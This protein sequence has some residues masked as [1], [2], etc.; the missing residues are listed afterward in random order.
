MLGGRVSRDQVVVRV[1]P[2]TTKREAKAAAELFAS[3]CVFGGWRT[4]VDAKAWQHFRAHVEASL[5]AILP[6]AVG[7]LGPRRRIAERI[8]RALA[9]K[10]DKAAL[11]VGRA[12]G[13]SAL[14]SLRE[15]LAVDRRQDCPTSPPELPASWTALTLG[16]LP[17][18]ALEHVGHMLAFSTLDAPYVGLEDVKTVCDP[19]A[20]A[21]LAWEA[22]SSWER[23]GAP[24]RERWMVEAIA[25]FG[26]DEVIRRTTP[27][28]RDPHVIT[29]VAHV[30]T[31]AAATELCTILARAKERKGRD[32]ALEA[33]ATNARLR[34]MSVEELEDSI[35]PTT[36]TGPKGRVSLGIDDRLDAYVET[37]GGSKHR[38][39]PS[40]A[41]SVAFVFRELQE[42]LAAIAEMRLASLERAMLTG[43]AW[44]PDAFRRAWTDHPVMSHVARC[45]VWRS[46]GTTFRVAEDGTFAGV[47]DD[48]VE[49]AGDVTVPH[50]A[51]MTTGERARWIELFADYRIVQPIE[52]LARRVIVANGSEVVLV[53]V[54]PTSQDRE[55]WD[56]LYARGFETVTRVG[57]KQAVKRRGA[58]SGHVFEA[59]MIASSRMV[60][61][62]VVPTPKDVDLVDLSELAHDLDAV[63]Q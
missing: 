39:V 33:F 1:A 49:V 40:Q 45:V 36:A 4:D 60:E 25:H 37:A 55:L 51:S 23:S 17:K 62:F 8:V 9:A 48:H 53:P 47:N 61:R 43:R 21:E 46:G 26:D 10:D 19:R 30:P 32:A 35:Q 38:D 11:G 13:K 52:Q 2:K 5:T 28:L 20:L 58:R 56:R 44:T 57:G 18:D 41:P 24:R 63:I 42:D 14:E 15:I 34:G 31:G 12:Y 16:D 59:E 54:R 50:V 3:M 6:I 22:A 27:A 7:E 29:V